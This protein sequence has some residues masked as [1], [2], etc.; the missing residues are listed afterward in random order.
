M[1][2]AICVNRF[3]TSGCNVVFFDPRDRFE[4]S[5]N[6]LFCK[7]SRYGFLCEM[8]TKSPAAK[9]ADIK[10]NATSVKLNIL[11]FFVKLML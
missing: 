4:L 9:A 10:A 11:G 7:L 6:G 3:T 2:V 8:V 1:L 5:I